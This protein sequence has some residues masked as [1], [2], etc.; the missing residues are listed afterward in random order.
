MFRSEVLM[1]TITE[2]V[3]IAVYLY[4]EGTLFEWDTG[5]SELPQC[6]Q[7]KSRTAP[8]FGHN[9]FLPNPFQIIISLTSHDSTLYS[10]NTES[11]IRETHK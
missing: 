3:I 4:L 2:L 7:A 10:L 11:V 6:L 1:V 9:R 5:Y 8:Q